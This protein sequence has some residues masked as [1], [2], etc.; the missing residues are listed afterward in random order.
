VHNSRRDYR[1]GE[2][3]ELL[4]QYTER[5]LQ[6]EIEKLLRKAQTGYESDILRLGR[7]VAG[8]FLTIEEWESYDWR[9]RYK[10]AEINIRVNLRMM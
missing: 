10:D 6:E 5:Y 1:E 4:R 9:S 7:Y 8:S 3:E 2:E